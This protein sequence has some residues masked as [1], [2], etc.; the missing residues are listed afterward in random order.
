MYACQRAES[1]PRQWTQCSRPTLSYE[2]GSSSSEKIG[3][4][5]VCKIGGKNESVGVL[6]GGTG[7][8]GIGVLVGGSGV[9]GMGVLVEGTGVGGSGVLVGGTGVGGMGVLVGG[10]G[11]GGTDVGGTGVG[12]I[13]VG[14]TDVG[15]TDVGG[16]DVGCSTVGS[17]VAVGDRRMRVF[18]GVGVR[19]VFV[20]MSANDCVRVAKVRLVISTATGIIPTAA[21]NKDT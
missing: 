6:V 12:G 11:V 3:G 17:L 19:G 21:G 8:G 13:G 1:N 5:S 9:G 10:T 18:V 15:G 7:V 2:G 20:G 14:G 4:S 16:T